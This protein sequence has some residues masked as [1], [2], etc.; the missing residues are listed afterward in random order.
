M[1]KITNTL[2]DVKIGRQGEVV[3]QRKYGEQIRRTASPKRAISSQAQIKH[4]ALYRAALGWRS[5]LSLPNRRYLEG[6][7]IANGIIDSYGIPLPWSRF[8]LKLYLEKVKFAVIEGL[9]PTTKKETG[10]LEHYDDEAKLTTNQTIRLD[11]WR[12]QSFTPLV[13][14]DLTKVELYLRRVGTIGQVTVSIRE[15]DDYGRPIGGDLVSNTFAGSELDTVPLWKEIALPYSQLAANQ[16]KA[17]V[18]RLAGGD[19]SNYLVWRVDNATA[20]YPRGTHLNSGNAGVSW[21][22]FSSMDSGFREYGTYDV[23]AI[24]PGILHVRHPSLL[25]VVHKRGGLAINGYDTLSSLDEEYLTGQVGLD[26]EVGDEI[27]ATSLPGIE[28][29]HQVL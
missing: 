2:G 12:A 17:I 15:T 18:V 13:T 14:H 16:Y 10:L 3:Y 27:L 4:R 9:L 29:K 25:K 7:C 5:Q 26:V 1:V 22:I 6:Y 20:S 21:N 8:A 11:L 19:G 24:T 23:P 28:Y